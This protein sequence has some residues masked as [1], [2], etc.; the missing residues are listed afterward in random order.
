MLD[1]LGLVSAEADRVVFRE[2]DGRQHTAV[3]HEHL[4]P[5][6]PASCGVAPEPQPSFGARLV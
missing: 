2:P 3:F 4:G 1:D 6:V 5:S